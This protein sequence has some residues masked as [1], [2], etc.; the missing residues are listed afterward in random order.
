[1]FQVL[2]KDGRLQPVHSKGDLEYMQRRGW[3]AVETVPPVAQTAEPRV[4]VIAPAPKR[5]YTRRA[6]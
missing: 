1:M 3:R 2:E 5:K 4:E 6:R